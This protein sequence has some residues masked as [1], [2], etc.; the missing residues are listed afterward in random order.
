MKKISNQKLSSKCF[1]NFHDTLYKLRVDASDNKAKATAIKLVGNSRMILKLIFTTFVCF[2][3][4]CLLAYGK[5][6]T[7]PHKFS[8]HTICGEKRFKQLE[9]KPTFLNSKQVGEYTY[10]V[11]QIMTKIVEMYP[12]QIG[13]S[14]LH[15]S[16]LLLA[17][18]IVL[19]DR[20][21]VEDSFK[22]IYTGKL[23]F[24]T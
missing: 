7:N 14:I 9:K 15:L 6:I 20:F 1:K 11:K 4:K 21:L 13:N 5:T 3:P 2:K 17:E 22:L 12:L 8:K 23:N 16:K 24:M 19:L 10:E 18:F